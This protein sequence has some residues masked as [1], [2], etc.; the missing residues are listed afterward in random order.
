MLLL[1]FL[2]YFSASVTGVWHSAVLYFVPYFVLLCNPVVLYNNTPM[3]MVSFGTF[4]FHCV[5][6]VANLKVSCMSVIQEIVRYAW[7]VKTAQIGIA[8]LEI[9]HNRKEVNVA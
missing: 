5:V 3:E 4:V 6:C 9:Q 7:G 1:L 8:V 2:F